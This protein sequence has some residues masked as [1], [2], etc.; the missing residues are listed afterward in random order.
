DLLFSFPAVAF[1]FV[2][3]YGELGQRERAMRLVKSGTN[4]RAIAAALQL[5]FWMKRLPPEAFTQPF[6]SALPDGERFAKRIVCFIPEDRLQAA[7]WLSGVLM[8]HRLAGD[9]FACWLAANRRVAL[10]EHR[11]RQAAIGL[12]AAFAWYSRHKQPQAS[13]LIGRR[14][15]P[16]QK[17]SNSTRAALMWSHEIVK[18]A[19][20]RPIRRGPGRYSR[21]NRT[22]GLVMVALRRPESLIEEG[23]LM[24]HCVASY[25]DDVARGDCLIFSLRRNGQRVATMEVVRSGARRQEARIEQLYGP[26]NS[27][28]DRATYAAA[29]AW[30]AARQT[31]AQH[32]YR[33]QPLATVAVDEVDTPETEIDVRRWVPLW[34]PYVDAV[35]GAVSGGVAPTAERVRVAAIVLR[36]MTGVR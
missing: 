35:P 34:Q 21:G 11:H 1:A 17:L 9:D 28:V 10:S 22:N 12:L 14:W 29:K 25:I 2:S 33:Q 5:P 7:A 13:A 19:A 20:M 15:S 3:G 16:Q 23:Q 6:G 24:N 26:S 30:V 36:T 27:R 18:F 31:G 32:S 4:L 8:A